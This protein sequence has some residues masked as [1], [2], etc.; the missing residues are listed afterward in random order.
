[1][2]RHT[3]AKRGKYVRLKLK[4]GATLKAKFIERK[5]AYYVF[6]RLGKVKASDIESF[7]IWKN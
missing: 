6:E 2:N 4:N 1:M 3:T 7:A 5:S